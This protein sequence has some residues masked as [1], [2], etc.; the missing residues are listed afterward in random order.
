MS[1]Y[2]IDKLSLEDR[3]APETERQARLSPDIS[4]VW[5]YSGT[6]PYGFSNVPVQGEFHMRRVGDSQYMG[7]AYSS[8]GL[9]G[10]FQSTV[11]GNVVRSD[12]RWSDASFEV[13]NGQLSSDGRVMEITDTAG[14]QTRAF[15]TN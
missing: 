1:K 6:C 11:S 9:T 12:I 5:S 3:K 2:F 4:G 8:L 15:L 7:Q 14:C 13:A 10:Q